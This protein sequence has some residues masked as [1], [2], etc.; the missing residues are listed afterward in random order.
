MTT[1]QQRVKDWMKKAGQECPDKPTM[2]SLEIRKL[3]ARLILEE[4][5]ETIE[6]GLGLSVVCYDPCLNMDGV[7]IEQGGSDPSLIELADGMADLQYVN[8]GTA[9]ACGIDLEPVFAEVCRSND[10]KWWRSDELD[11]PSWREGW[12]FERLDNGYFCVTDQGGKI[13][14]PPGY[15]PANIAPI[16]GL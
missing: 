5:L 2:P 15:S 7:E 12:G 3:R 1:E 14:K 13:R 6:K 11:S 10:S 16:L 4:A 8:L 9:V